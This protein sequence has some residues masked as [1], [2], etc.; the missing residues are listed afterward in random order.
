MMIL[1]DGWFLAALIC[2]NA[3]LIHRLYNSQLWT[4]F[5]GRP[6]WTSPIACKMW[7]LEGVQQ[8]DGVMS[9]RILIAIKGFVYDV[10]DKGS[11]HYGP[12]KTEL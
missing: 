11:I 9:P 1:E 12:G 6:R 4:L 7:T 8:Y 10:R 3:L 2:V 5:M